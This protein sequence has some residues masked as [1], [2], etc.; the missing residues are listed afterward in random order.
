MKKTYGYIAACP[1]L[2]DGKPCGGPLMQNTP[3]GNVFVVFEKS[4]DAKKHLLNF[5]NPE[6]GLPLTK[7][8]K[9]ELTEA[10]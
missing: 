10:K 5:E 1:F 6:T 4:V 8:I 7:L 2:H 9:L 3:E